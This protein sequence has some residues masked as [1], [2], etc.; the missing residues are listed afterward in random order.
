MAPVKVK[1]VF[2]VGETTAAVVVKFPGF[3]VKLLAPPA[4]SVAEELLQ[5]LFVF[6]VKLTDGM[7]LTVSVTKVVSCAVQVVGPGPVARIFKVE[8]ETSGPVESKILPPFPVT[9][10]PKTELF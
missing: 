5:I 4:V 1:V 6:E 10:V 2:V 9:G 7:L 8:L 3:N